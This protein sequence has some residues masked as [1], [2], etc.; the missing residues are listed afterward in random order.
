MS[1][2]RIGVLLGKELGTGWR[3]VMFIFAV[4]VPV[5]LTIVVTL[6]FGTLVT[7]RARLGLVDQ[8]ASAVA[9]RAAELTSLDVGTYGSP[10]A[11]R[12]AVADGALDMGFVLPAG[13]D[14]QVQGGQ[15]VTLTA[16][17][18]GES[19][20]RSRAMAATAFV[21]LIRDVAGQEAPVE[22]VT[23][24]LGEGINVPWESRLLPFIV[25]M[26]MILGGSMVPA[27]LLVEEKQKRTLRALTT[28]PASLGEVFTAKG[29]LGVIVSVAMA[30]LTLVLN[31][32]WGPEPALLLL[33]LVLGSVMAAGIGLLLGA[34]IKDINTLFSVV[35]AGGILLYAP[36]LV[37]LF[38]DIPA[39]IGQL[40]PTY[41]LIHPVVEITQRGA[42]LAEVAPE[43]AV[44][45]VLDALLAVAVAL[46]VRRAPM[47]E[48]VLNP[49]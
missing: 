5:V 17:V 6:V 24:L 35:K 4:A 9:A 32:A 3:N 41:Y 45:A 25:L 38:P 49:A 27:A 39:W 21:S 11:L 40:F 31:R 7:G 36:V 23:T 48:G 12:A 30:A 14:A 10:V 2:R 8:G 1:I 29:M 34:F 37:Y 16:Y 28:S 43:L 44:L 42:G 22:I 47:S 13:F 26:A 18:W 46:V 33:A 15:P 20:F 19:T